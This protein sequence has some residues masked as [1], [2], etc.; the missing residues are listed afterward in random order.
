M[1]LICR[2]RQVVKPPHFLCGN[3]GSNPLSCTR[4]WDCGPMVRTVPC[5]GTGRSSILRSLANFIR[6]QCNGSTADFKSVKTGGPSL[7]VWVRVL[8]GVPNVYNFII[9]SI[10]IGTQPTRV[11]YELDI[12]PISDHRWD[13]R[14]NLVEKREYVDASEYHKSKKLHG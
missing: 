5:H 6:P 8:Q 2:I 13:E 1:D 7:E 11:P 14:L 10:W 12:Y 4:F 9:Y 3:K